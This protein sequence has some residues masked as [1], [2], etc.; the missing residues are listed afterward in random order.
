MNK[1]PKISV[2]MPNYNYIEFIDQAIKSV[3]NQNLNNWELLIIQDGNIDNSEKIIKK[4]TKYFPDKIKVYRNKKRKGL[5]YCANL[6]LKKSR[7]KYI[8]R[9]DPDDYLDE[10]ALLLMSSLLDKK[11]SVNLIYPDFFYVDKDSNILDI[12]KRKKIGVEDIALD[13]PAHGACTMIRKNKLI[14]LG[15]YNEKFKAQDG[16]DIWYKFFDKK[17]FYNISTPLFFYRQ[18]NLSITK[19]ENVILRE[20]KKIKNYHFKR[21]DKNYKILFIV[22]AKKDTENIKNV[23]FKKIKN[24][25]LIDFTLDQL[26]NL[27]IKHKIIVNTD[28]K[29]TVDY[30]KKMKN[31]NFISIMR[32][33]KLIETENLKLEEIIN[34]SISYSVDKNYFI[35]DIAVYLNSNAPL[36]NINEIMEGVHTLILHNFDKVI[37]VYEDFDLHY[38]H[39]KNGLEALAKRRHSELRIEREALFVDNRA[40]SV[41]WTKLVSKKT[42]ILKSKIGH[43]IMPRNSSYNIRTKDDLMLIKQLL[44]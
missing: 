24:Q 16:Y 6:A 29:K 22:G 44:K 1:I 35:P 3:I 7:G 10:S 18:H 4:Y 12:E 8:I 43:V 36:K 37:S 14:K 33:K 21:K 42:N 28:N 19:N 15:G 11:K 25:F 27:K 39:S 30:I 23:L 5:Q 9:L 38:M 32:N 17:N 2:Y 34:E 13:L 41:Y 20:R 40:F 26:K 31:N